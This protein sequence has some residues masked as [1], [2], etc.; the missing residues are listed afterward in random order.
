[1]SQRATN[2][3]KDLPEPIIDDIEHESDN[4][5]DISIETVITLKEEEEPPY[6][7]L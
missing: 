6:I 3:D 5:R 1:M 4:G 7:N 2:A